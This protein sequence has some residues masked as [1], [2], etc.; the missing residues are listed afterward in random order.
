MEEFLIESSLS[1]SMTM[2]QYSRSRFLLQ[3][4]SNYNLKKANTIMI[5]AVPRTMPILGQKIQSECSYG[6]NIMAYR[7]KM[8]LA[9][10][11]STISKNEKSNYAKQ[12]DISCAVLPGSDGNDDKDLRLRA[13][14]VYDQ[15]E[16]RIY[17]M[18]E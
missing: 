10:S 3:D 16:M 4:F 14:C 9:D 18:G 11:T 6:T 5:F 12:E 13:T 1:Q 2:M 17:R 8:P 7:F 15:E